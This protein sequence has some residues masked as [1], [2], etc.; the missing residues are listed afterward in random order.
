MYSSLDISVDVKSHYA[1][2]KNRS[3]TMETFLLFKG[4]L[5]HLVE[6]VILIYAH[7]IFMELYCI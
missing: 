3:A 4:L 6:L 5:L 7:V 2:M 1:K